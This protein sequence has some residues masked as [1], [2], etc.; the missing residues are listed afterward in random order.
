MR[1]FKDRDEALEFVTKELLWGVAAGVCKDSALARKYA[2]AGIP[3]VSYGSITKLPRAGNAGGNFFC[4]ERGN[5]INAWGIPNKGFDE[6]LSEL[7]QLRKDINSLGSQLW[8]SI[9]AG[10]KFDPDEYN[11]MALHLRNDKA[12]DVVEGNFSCGNMKVGDHFKPIVCY[13]L[14]SFRDGVAALKRG[15]GD[16]KTSA[17]L[18]P[19]TERR[20]LI[21]NVEI[22]LEHGID[23]I[24]LANTIPNSY[25]EKPDGSP[26]ITMGLGGLGGAALRPMVTGM[27]KI[28]APML[29]GTNTKLIAAG[30]VFDGA[31]AYH[32]L[33]HGA[34]GFVCSTLLWRSNFRP[35]CMQ[36]IIMSKQTDYLYKTDLLDWLVEQGLPD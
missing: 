10:D 27:I 18:T 7:P 24:V 6:H 14:P 23:Y 12:A 16:L 36:E 3:I 25:L 33:K 35:E 29:K 17:K 11:Y 28:I 20:F 15:A 26:A 1:R 4:D 8:A 31:S 9:S 13:D 30:G 22:C 21:A 2:Q 5:S 34:H 19:T 32:Y